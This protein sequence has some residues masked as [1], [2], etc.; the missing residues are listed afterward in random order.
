MSQDTTKEFSLRLNQALRDHPFA[1][2]EHGRQRWLLRELEKQSGISVSPN[3]VSKWVNGQARP[4]LDYI[5]ALSRL[6][7]VDEL[8]LNMGQKPIMDTPE[9]AKQAA[10]SSGSALA[11]AGIIEMCGGRVTFPGPDETGLSLRVDFGLGQ[12]G[13]L[14]VDGNQKGSS[15]T[16][17]IDEPVEDNKIIYF[18][19]T[20]ELETGT[21]QVD[22]LDLT[23]VPRQKMGGFSIIQG[24]LRKDGRIKVDGQRA[25]L[26]PARSVEDL[27]Y[28]R[29]ET[30]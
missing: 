13:M 24:E 9:T 12:V 22:L 29:N 23:D 14:I 16:F 15:V 25:L 11:L 8:W 5:R 21:G 4:R 30:T 2:D 1:P 10:R 18:R 7:K 26:A 3:T 27:V 20:S 6:L 19:Y 28:A 17:I